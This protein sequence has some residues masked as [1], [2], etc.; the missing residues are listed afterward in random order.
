MK[1]THLGLIL[2]AIGIALPI[3]GGTA[4]FLSTQLNPIEEAE[5]VRKV[6]LKDFQGQVD[7]I[8]SE[9]GT[10][11]TRLK[12]EFQAKKSSISVIGALHG[13]LLS[14]SQ[15]GSLAPLDAVIKGLGDRQFISSLV[16]LGKLGQKEQ[17]YIPWMQATYIMAANKKALQYLPKG[18]DVN[19]LTYAQLLQW[20][21]N[22]T[23]ATGERKLGFPAG[24]KG[25]IHRFL[26]GYLYPSFTGGLVRT[27]KNRDAARMWSQFKEIWKYA[28][29]RSTSSSIYQL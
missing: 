24:D 11:L 13:D 8:P 15:E 6:I 16:T 25:L 23:K 19:T 2:L 4:T 10:F 29:P 7:F 26:Q 17:Y 18:S 21:K 22:I 9:S 3:R 27:F 14:L 1:K 12:A 20:G 28:N 5:K